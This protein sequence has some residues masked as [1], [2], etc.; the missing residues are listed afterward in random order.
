MWDEAMYNVVKVV[1]LV[2]HFSASC[3]RYGLCEEETF[4]R[5]F[6]SIIKELER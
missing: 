1:D 5:N 4:P 3:L 2:R 6:I